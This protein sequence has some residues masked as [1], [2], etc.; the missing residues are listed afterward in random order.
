MAKTYQDIQNSVFTAGNKMDW[1]NAMIRSNGIPL[2]IYSVFS[3]KADA[4]EFATNNP[5][6]YEGQ[7]LAVTEN[8]ETIVYVI[9]PTGL[10]EVGKATLGDDKSITLSDESILS[11]KGFGVEYYK[12]NSDTKTWEA[13]PS[14]WDEGAAGAQPKVIN[15]GTAENPSY[16]VA[17]YQPSTITVEG[18]SSAVGD[19]QTTVALKADKADVYTKTETDAKISA[20]GTV[21]N[22]KGSMTKE[23]FEALS[24]LSDY[25]AGDVLIVEGAEYVLIESTEEE[26]V[27]KRF[28]QLGDPSGVTALAER[29]TTAEGKITTLEG[30]ADDHEGRLDVIEQADGDYINKLESVVSADTRATV[31]TTDKVATITVNSA[32]VADKVSNALTFGSKTFDG[33]EAAEVKLT[34]LGGV[35]ATKVAD[36]ELGLVKSSTGDD[37]VTVAA[38]GIMTVSKVSSA[39]NADNAASAE[40]VKNKLTI[41]VD[42]TETTYDGSSAETVTITSP[43]IAA[44]TKAGIVKASEASA[45][46]GVTVDAEGNMTV[47]NVKAKSTTGV[48][49]L[50]SKTFNGSENVEVTLANLGFNP[51]DYATA[52]QGTKADTAVQSITIADK[53]AT[54]VSGVATLSADDLKAGLGLGGA[55]YKAEDY[56]ATKTSVDDIS[57]DYVSK[58]NGGVVTGAVTFNGAVTVPNVAAD[59][60]DATATNKK[61]VDETVAAA[62]AAN[63]AMTFKG[64]L[65][66][67]GNIQTLPTTNVKNGDTYKVAADGTY[68][69]K[70][71]KTGDMFIALVTGS[72]ETISLSWELIPS[73]DEDGN[74]I[75]GATLAKDQLI[76]GDGSQQ[77]KTLAAGTENQVLRVTNVDNNLVP[78]WSDEKTTSVTNDVAD[79][80][81]TVTKTVSGSDTAYDVKVAKVNVNLLDQTE[82]DT[83]ILNGGSS[84]L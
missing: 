17:W 38:D 6:A 32:P 15:V 36:T 26:I 22:L 63:D 27:T 5:V 71:A 2:D 29:V 50:G 23:Q 44:T 72:G 54:V 76:V 14:A 45:E 77:V 84:I 64:L 49:T 28:E 67:E 62:I 51:D 42:G 33:S 12:Y 24:D 70:A 61:Y 83:L 56:Y 48:L 9:A 16:E 69:S 10:E 7:I 60:A 66:G 59:S 53:S 1:T 25:N 37:H 78:T 75:A 3:S 41:S 43:G 52:A 47:V 30:T 57:A 20:L 80:S 39:T 46:N 79:G 55:A 58:A 74:V 73:A 68:D 31:N 34:D 4:I 65:G 35:A 8:G 13:S 11:I 21:F 19:L 82:G 18:L 81:I 40:K